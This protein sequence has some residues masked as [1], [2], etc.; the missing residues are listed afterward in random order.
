MFDKMSMAHRLLLSDANDDGK[1]EITI[2]PLV[3]A[4]SSLPDYPGLTPLIYYRIDELERYYIKQDFDGAKCMVWT[5]AAWDKSP[6]QM[7]LTAGFE[8]IW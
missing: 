4:K 3:S 5:S 6:R 8:G 7:I 2:V 1:S